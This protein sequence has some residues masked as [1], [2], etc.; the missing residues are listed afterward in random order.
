[1]AEYEIANSTDASQ[2]INF[3]VKAWEYWRIGR[4]GEYKIIYVVNSSLGSVLCYEHRT[5]PPIQLIKRSEMKAAGRLFLHRNSLGI[6][7]SQDTNA[8]KVSVWF[9]RCSESFTT[10]ETSFGCIRADKPTRAQ[11]S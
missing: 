4:K 9:K 6:S 11:P 7:V 8:D 3:L 2:A 10:I 5:E 1:M